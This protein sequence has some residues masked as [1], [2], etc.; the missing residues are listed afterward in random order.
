M[1]IPNINGKNNTNLPNHQPDDN[2]LYHL[3][4][5]QGQATVPQF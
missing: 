3:D 5:E 4:I 1:I 2:Y